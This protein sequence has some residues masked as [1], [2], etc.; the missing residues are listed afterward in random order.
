VSDHQQLVFI[1]VNNDR[2]I[3]VQINKSFINS[4]SRIDDDMGQG[5]TGVRLAVSLS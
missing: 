5:D 4:E 1:D 3:K 2:E